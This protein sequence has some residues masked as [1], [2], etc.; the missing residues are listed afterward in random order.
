MEQVDK[1]YEQLESNN[2]EI[3]DDEPVSDVDAE[4]AERHH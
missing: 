3:V 2:I 1:L 4:P